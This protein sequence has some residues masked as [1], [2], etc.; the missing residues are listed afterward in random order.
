MAQD[1]SVTDVWGG[2]APA[3]VTREAAAVEGGDN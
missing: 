2:V 1:T 3:S